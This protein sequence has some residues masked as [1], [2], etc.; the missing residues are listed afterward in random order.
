MEDALE[1]LKEVMQADAVVEV[2]ANVE[3]VEQLR[4]VGLVLDRVGKLLPANRTL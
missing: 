1:D 4:D 2:L 3:Q